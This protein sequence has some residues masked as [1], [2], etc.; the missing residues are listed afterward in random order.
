MTQY[1]TA[2][3]LRK[4]RVNNTQYHRIQC[5]MLQSGTSADQETSHKLALFLNYLKVSND[6]FKEINKLTFSIE[7]YITS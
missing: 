3:I 5:T 1:D 2:E 7:A 6:I 4:I